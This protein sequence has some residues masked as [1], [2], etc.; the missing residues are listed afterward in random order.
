MCAIA[1]Q[2]LNQSQAAFEGLLTMARNAFR[3]IDQQSFAISA[4]SITVAEQT[5]SNAFDF[6]HKLV[7]IKEFQELAQIRSE[8][9]GRQTQVLSDQTKELSQKMMQ[10]VQEIVKAAQ[11]GTAGSWRRSDA[12]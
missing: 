12:A 10:G 3:S 4:N 2:N 7:R 8:F 11:E 6:A 9:V 1:E 5:F